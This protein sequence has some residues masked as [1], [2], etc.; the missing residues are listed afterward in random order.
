MM[1]LAPVVLA[2]LCVA[3]LFLG[4]DSV[5]YL[6]WREARDAEVA[7]EMLR[8]REALTPLYGRA[9]LFEKPVLAYAPEV[10]ARR[11][12]PDSPLRSRQMRPFLAV[13][14]LLRTPP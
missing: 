5:G 12:A 2:T 11:L 9:A 10:L 7:R 13:L 14:L 1:R 4:L 6:D 3:V 8:R